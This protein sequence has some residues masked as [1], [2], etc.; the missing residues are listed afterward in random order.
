MRLKTKLPYESVVAFAYA[1]R[2]RSSA[3]NEVVTEIISHSDA[4][5]KAQGLTDNGLPTL[6]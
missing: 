5:I 6:A 4:D 1:L 3:Y 2:E